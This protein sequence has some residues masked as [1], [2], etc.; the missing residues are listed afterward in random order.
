MPGHHGQTKPGSVWADLCPCLV[1]L[2]AQVGTSLLRQEFMKSLYILTIFF[3]NS[4]LDCPFFSATVENDTYQLHYVTAKCVRVFSQVSQYGQEQLQ[5][6]TLKAGVVFELL[7]A[8]RR[9]IGQ[10]TISATSF[11]LIHF[12]F[13]TFCIP[14]CRSESCIQAGHKK[15]RTIA[16]MGYLRVLAG[17]V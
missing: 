4:R 3:F 8:R 5:T 2:M 13:C 10:S 11:N 15:P 1:R 12:L 7:S 14:T 16:A 9:Q 17:P 6:R